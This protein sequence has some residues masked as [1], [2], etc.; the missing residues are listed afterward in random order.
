MATLIRP[1]A[2]PLTL[3]ST[4][5]DVD[6]EQPVTEHPI[7]SGAAVVDHS[8]DRPA[9]IKIV[10]MVS[11]VGVLETTASDVRTWL[12]GS[13]GQLV[14]ASLPIHGAM[15]NLMVEGWTAIYDHLVRQNVTIRL[16]EVDFAEALTVPVPPATAA[17][18]GLSSASSGG[19]NAA[20]ADRTLLNNADV[21][22]GNS[23]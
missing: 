6:K 4:S 10:A 5:I 16:K 22:V 23:R 20:S 18:G 14:S 12:E 19:S 7:E 2:L 15:S 17:I 8:Q 11:A 9:N 13:R 21:A 3:V 1:G